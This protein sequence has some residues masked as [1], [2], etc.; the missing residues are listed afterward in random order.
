M[1]GL[2]KLLVVLQRAV[3]MSSRT[4][5]Q[6]PIPSEML[7]ALVMHAQWLY[8][9]VNLEVPMP[10]S[11]LWP[12]TVIGGVWVSTSGLGLECI[13]SSNSRLPIANQ[14]VLLCLFTPVGILSAVL[15]IEA[16]IHCLRPHKTAGAGHHFASVVMSMVF[17]FLPIWVKTALSLLPCI[18][19]DTPVVPPYQAEAVGSWWAEDMS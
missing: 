6:R 15:A 17:M 11:L 5:L 3:D 16:A 18:G 1:I 4:D 7:R 9:I 10:Q 12:V 8:I 2:V 19:L 14:K 13:L